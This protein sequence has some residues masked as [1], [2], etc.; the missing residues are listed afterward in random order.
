MKKIVTYRD[1]IAWQKSRQLVLI[2]YK[3]TS[4]FPKSEAFVLTSQMRRSAV[5]ITSNIAEGFA[6]QGAKEKV[7]FYLHAKS[8]LAELQSQLEIAKDLNYLTA[9]KYNGVEELVVECHKLLSGLIKNQ[10]G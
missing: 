7:Q 3:I 4:I 1:L 9:R 2:I 5:S 6:R 10:K 8:S